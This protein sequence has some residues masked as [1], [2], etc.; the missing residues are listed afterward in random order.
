MKAKAGKQL[1]SN[2]N[3]VCRTVCR[4]TLMY[5]KIVSITERENEVSE[6]D[7]ETNTQQ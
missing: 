3:I 4:E 5:D 1:R 7:M 6:N 2:E